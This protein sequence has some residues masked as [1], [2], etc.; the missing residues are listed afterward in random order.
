M[1]PT[2]MATSHSAGGSLAGTTTCCVLQIHIE[3]N[4]CVNILR[5]FQLQQQ[6]GNIFL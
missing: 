6:H 2:V 4:A 5:I 3:M 1:M